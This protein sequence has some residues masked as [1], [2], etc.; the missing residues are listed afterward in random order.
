[1]EELD[2]ITLSTR[3]YL[4]ISRG[5]MFISRGIIKINVGLFAITVGLKKFWSSYTKK[6]GISTC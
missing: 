2:A 3:G 1:V 5:I 6:T 4:G